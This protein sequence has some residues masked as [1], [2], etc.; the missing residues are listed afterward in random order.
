MRSSTWSSAAAPLTMFPLEQGPGGGS[1]N[2]FSAACPA[3]APSK[4]T[5]DRKTRAGVLCVP[6]ATCHLESKSLTEMNLLAEPV[7]RMADSTR[8]EARMQFS[9][10]GMVSCL[11]P[12]PAAMGT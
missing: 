3:S 10:G 9:H 8:R 7:L 6:S 11:Q 12:L 1:V 5:E 2:G 4:H